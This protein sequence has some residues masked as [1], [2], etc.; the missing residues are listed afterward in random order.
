MSPPSE[1]TQLLLAR[2]DGDNSALEKLI[3]LVYDSLRSDARF[4]ELLQQVGLLPRT[5]L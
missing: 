3:P 2:S 5:K 4:S 1:V